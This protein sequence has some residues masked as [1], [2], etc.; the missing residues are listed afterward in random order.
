MNKPALTYCKIPEI[1]PGLAS[2]YLPTFS[3]IFYPQ[4]LVHWYPIFA[5]CFLVSFEFSHSDFTLSPSYKHCCLYTMHACSVL[6]HVRPH[7]LQPAGLLCPW[8][9]S[10]KN[11]GG[12]HFP[13]PRNLPHPGIKPMSIASPELEMRAS[14]MKRRA[15][16]LV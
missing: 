15:C 16:P 10:G 6:N 11:T 1:L 8:N 9:F 13:P 4:S 12:S 3:C 2:F 7:G 5:S 14:R